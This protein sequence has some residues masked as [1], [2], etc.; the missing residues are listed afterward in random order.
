M[1]ELSPAWRAWG[2][3]VAAVT[4]LTFAIG[5]LLATLDGLNITT[6]EPVFTP[7]AVLPERII[8][9]LQN[10]A[11]RFPWVLIATLLAIVSFA[12]LAA[13]GAVLRRALTASDDPRG[14]VVQGAFFLAATIG[15]IGEL[16]FLGGQAVA[17]DATY[18]DCA[19]ADPQVIARGGILD[20]V[21][22]I[23]NW[24]Q[25][26]LAV[27]FAVGLVAAASL[28][29]QSDGVPRGWRLLTTWLAVLLAV[30]AV[31][32]AGF[33]PLAGA[34]QWDI[35]ANLVTGVPSLIALLVL[36]PWW[37]L[38]LRAWLREEPAPA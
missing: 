6:R 20:L 25:W 38:W 7:G 31:V 2:R 28:A 8:T 21:T 34:M 4:A 5:T 37:A 18:C 33:P 13:L 23:Q 27:S 24:M 35:D 15:V 3:M 1:P 22:S 11:Q 32:G 9:V 19:F 14:W 17:S 10:Q 29:R 16:A 30:I 26:G 36:I 12:M